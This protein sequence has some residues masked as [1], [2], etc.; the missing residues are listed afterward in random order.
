VIRQNRD[1]TADLFLGCI[2][3]SVTDA[4]KYL[5]FNS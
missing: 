3:P 5:N 4:V 2:A 1:S